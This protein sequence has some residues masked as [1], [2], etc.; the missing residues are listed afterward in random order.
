MRQV[1]EA[2]KF[3]RY[4]SWIPDPSIIGGVSGLF[5]PKQFCDLQVHNSKLWGHRREPVEI[6]W[7]L[8]PERLHTLHK[9][10]H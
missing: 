8:P 4:F 10:V 6:T 2:V 9:G 7:S 1:H 3:F 5:Q